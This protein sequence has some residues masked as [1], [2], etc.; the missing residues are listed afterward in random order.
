MKLN[1]KLLLWMTIPML[2]MFFMNLMISF[3]YWSYDE[4][5]ELTKNFNHPLAFCVSI[6]AIV[7]LCIII[8]T[9]MRLM[10]VSDEIDDLEKAK[11]EYEEATREM[12]TARDKYTDLLI[13]S[14]SETL[15]K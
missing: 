2:L 12:K 13:N 11:K 14:S 4:I 5:P 7:G 3:S 9:S 15:K 6:I 8:L 1:L 10:Y